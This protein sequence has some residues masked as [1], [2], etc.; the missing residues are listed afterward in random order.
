MSR[1]QRGKGKGPGTPGQAQQQSRPQAG[2]GGGQGGGGG[3]AGG[4]WGPLRD[5][6]RREIEQASLALAFAER[7]HTRL[8]TQRRLFVDFSRVMEQLRSG[9]LERVGGSLSRLFEGGQGFDLQRFLRDL[10]LALSHL[11]AA[12]GQARR[13]AARDAGA[14]RTASVPP[15][16]EAGA[17]QETSNAAEPASASAE[18]AAAEMP[19]ATALPEGAG[20]ASGGTPAD[21]GADAVAEKSAASSVPAEEATPPAGAAAGAPD[22]MSAD[23]AGA[24]REGPVSPRLEMRSKLLAAA[25]QLAKAATAY[26]RN[27]AT[28][29]RAA[30][31]RR[32]PGPWRSDREVLEEARRAVDFAR[33]LFDA[34]AGAWADQPLAQGGDDA[35]AAEMDRFLAWTQ[36]DR[37]VELAVHGDP[38]HTGSQPPPSGKKVVAPSPAPAA[39]SENGHGSTAAASDG[40]PAAA[41]SDAPASDEA[42]TGEAAPAAD[43][44]AG[45]AAADSGAAAPQGEPSQG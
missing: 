42:R 16:A 11:A 20:E 26:R 41:S 17:A 43:H 39:P 10:P 45:D 6:V 7:L 9:A 28:V 29:K 19:T 37:Y 18:A 1:K 24:A 2:G 8:D 30:A 34:Y 32:S 33:Q 40:A 27:V 36:L 25:P 13:T 23:P 15:K 5:N 35:M 12:E 38:R 31:P 14:A 21:P 4:G 3:G 22:A 44:A